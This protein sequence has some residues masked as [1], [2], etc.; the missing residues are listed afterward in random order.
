MLLVQRWC[1]LKGQVV[2][3]LELARHWTLYFLDALSL[4][5]VMVSPFW[6]GKLSLD[7]SRVALRFCLRRERVSVVVIDKIWTCLL[8]QF[9]K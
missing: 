1:L 7:H 8:M 2:V 5:L 9:V 6:L 3:V 4:M